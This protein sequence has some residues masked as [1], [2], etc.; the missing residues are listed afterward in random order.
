MSCLAAAAAIALVAGPLG[1][2][3]LRIVGVIIAVAGA[4]ARVVIAVQRARLEGKREKAEFA[5]RCRVAVKPIGE[6]DPTLIGVD[7]AAQTILAGG[8]VPDYVGRTVDETLREAV[9]AALDGGGRWLVVV[10][11]GSKVGKSRTLFQA[12]REAAPVGGLAFLAPVDGAALRSLLTPG[13]GVGGLAD[14]AVLWLDDLE[15]FLNQG[16]TLQTLREWHAG[17]IGRIVAATYGGK[18]SEL[19]A[20]SSGLTTIASD[21]LQHACEIPLEETTADEL[22]GFRSRLSDR[23]FEDVER[24]GLAAYLVAGP[25]LER[26][27]ITG[28]HAPGE[29]ACREGVAVVY[30]A[31]DWA[32]CGRTDPLSEEMLRGLWPSHLPAGIRATDD[33]FDVGLAWALR[34]V[35]GTIALLQRTGSYQAYDYVVR[36]VRDKPGAEAPRDP[37]WT[38][39]LQTATDVQAFAVGMAAYGW[40]RFEDAMTGLARARESSIDQVAVTAG[41][42][43]GAVLGELERSV[44]AIGVYDEVVA[45]FADAPDPALR[46]AV[47]W[48]LSARQETEEGAD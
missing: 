21:V 36:L 44:E 43:L 31:T 17:R 41:Y 27:L 34:P 28:R 46:E 30:A 18:G 47:A 25:A 2:A 26:K 9:A 39:A 35:A 45:R 23:E 7:P 19:I 13:Q 10:V 1:V 6:I 14:R 22:S 15:P 32:R 38:A 12:L 29:D 40:S 42:N 5:G 11:G 4:C 24:H 48:A 33:V 16:V 8:E 20:P 3:W 37:S